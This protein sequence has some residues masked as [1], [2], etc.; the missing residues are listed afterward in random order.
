MEK[1]LEALHR[2][3]PDLVM[4]DTQRPDDANLILIRKLRAVTSVPLLMMIHAVAEDQIV[5]V[6]N[7]GVDECIVKPI[8]PGLIIAKVS[9]WLRHSGKKNLS[10]AQSI[11]LKDCLLLSNERTLTIG[12]NIPIK[13]TGLEMR[14]LHLLMSRSPQAVG[15][16]EILDRV[17]DY[18]ADANFA[19]LKNVVYRLRQRIEIDP[20]QPRYLQ[21]VSGI[22]YRFV[23]P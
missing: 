13:L 14:L 23:V 8:G 22:G 9:A 12:N 1:G 19:V 17:W 2:E 11:R 6:Y 5:N 10:T 3:F 16:D 7:A 21:T 20:T 15:H 4:V 18:A